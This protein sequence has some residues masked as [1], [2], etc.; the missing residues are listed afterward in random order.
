[1]RMSLPWLVVE[2]FGFLIISSALSWMFLPVIKGEKAPRTGKG[3]RVAV[4]VI[5]IGA[6]LVTVGVIGAWS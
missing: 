1:M 5:A 3:G 4:L 2:I 6:V